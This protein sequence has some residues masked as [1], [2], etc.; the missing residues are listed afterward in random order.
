M[1]SIVVCIYEVTYR[2]CSI[3]VVQDILTVCA[4]YAVRRVDS[5]LYQ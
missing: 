1:F 3:D 5:D 4:V 2:C